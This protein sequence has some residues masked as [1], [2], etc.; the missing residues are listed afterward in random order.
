MGVINAITVAALPSGKHEGTATNKVI[1]A[2]LVISFAELLGR[3]QG[4][5]LAAPAT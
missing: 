2:G 5:L 1:V 3:S 4:L